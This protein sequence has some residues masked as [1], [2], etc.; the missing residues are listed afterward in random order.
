MKHSNPCRPLLAAATAALAT[1]GAPSRALANEG[2]AA[3]AP[4]A[5][6]AYPAQLS[7]RPL[8]LPQ[9]MAQAAMSGGY[10]WLDDQQ[11][12]A[13]VSLRARVGITDWW[14]A[15]V[16]T[17]FLLTPETE[18]LEAASL[19]TRIL[20]YDSAR[21][22]FAPGVYVPVDFDQ[23]DDAHLLPG[24]AIDATTRI[25]ITERYSV[26][27]G[28]GLVPL[29]IGRR[30]SVNL[31]CSVIAQRDPRMGLIFSGQLFHIRLHGD[32]R[33]SR[34]ASAPVALTLFRSVGNWID[35]GVTYASGG[36]DHGLSGG[37]VLRR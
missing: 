12:T 7:L 23:A 9:G 11:N 21:I 34:F 10:W 2:E 18:W 1:Y 36:G 4:S 29:S 27:C 15:S 31:N 37:V 13:P 8:T 30:A 35:L 14:D 28:D 6:Q 22:D 19:S 33:E 26:T 32:V 20:A 25:H 17:F 24:V 3:D 16:H 5:T